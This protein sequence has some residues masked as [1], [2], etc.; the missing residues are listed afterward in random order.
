[1]LQHIQ[2]PQ[3]VLDGN[4]K[5][6][7]KGKSI[8]S[9]KTF[10]ASSVTNTSNFEEKERKT[11]EENKLNPRVDGIVIKRK[12]RSQ[13]PTFLL[14]FEIFNQNV[15]NCL[16]DS[17]DSSN[18]IPFLVCKKLNAEPRMSKTN[19]TQLDRS[20]VKVFGELKDVLIR[21]SSNYKGHQTIDIIVVDIPEAYQMILSR[22]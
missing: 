22:D 18:V 6:T 12:S 1:M 19:I 16:V 7:L 9:T 21:L 3:D 4:S 2:S 14:T 5:V 10:K 15:Y 20:Q 11:M 13:T 17:G 8:K